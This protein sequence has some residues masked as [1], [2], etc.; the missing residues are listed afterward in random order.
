MKTIYNWIFTAVIALITTT[1]F[2]QG[3]VT[4]TVVDASL[5]EPLPGANVMVRGS[6]SGTSTDFDGNFTLDVSQDSGTI[7][8][9]YIGFI[10]K[11]VSYTLSG[12]TANIGTVSLQPDAEELEGV[13]VVGSGVIDL[14][15]DRQTPIA[16]S[17]VKAEEIA[18]KSGNQEFPEILK[19]TPSIYTSKGGGGFGDSRMQTRGFDQSNT[20]FLINGQPINGME[21]GRMYW[22]NWQG[23][24]DVANA[25]QVQRGLGSSKLAI[26]SVGGTI[27]IVTKTIDSKEGGFLQTMVGNDNYLKT[28][29]YYSTGLSEKGWS[30]STLLGHWQGDGYNHHMEGNGQTYFI[31]AGYVPNDKHSFNFLITGA[32][33]RHN[34]RN[35]YTLATLLEKGAKYNDQW[36]YLNGEIVNTSGNYYHKPIANLNWDWNISDRAELSTV[37]YASWGRGGSIGLR[38][39]G[40]QREDNFDLT[41]QY[42]YNRSI[43]PNADGLI[44]G[45]RRA[46]DRRADILRSSVNEH[47]WYGVVSNFNYEINDVFSFNV[48]FDGRSYHGEHYRRV[49]DFLGL[50]G[51]DDDTNNEQLGSDYVVTESYSVNPWKATFH[52]TPRDQRI[53]Y[54]NPED[55]R[56]FGGFGQFEYATEKLSAF[57]QGAVSTQSNQRFDYFNYVEGNEKSEKVT[58][59]GFNVKAGVNYNINNQHNVF[60]NAGHYSRQP[61]QDNMFLNFRNDVNPLLTNEKITGFEAGYGFRSSVFA[62]NVNVYQTTWDDRVVSGSLSTGEGFYQFQGV[63]QVHQGIEVD[64]TARPAQGLQFKGFTSIGQ[65]E[66]DG[67]ASQTVY[68]DNQNVVAEGDPLYLDGVKVGDGAQ[69]TIGVGGQYEFLR[70][71]SVDANY[72]HYD[73]LYAGFLPTDAEF[74]TPDNRGSV[75][76]P[77]YGLL[78]AGLTFDWKVKDNHNLVLRFNMNNVLDETYIAESLTNRHVEEGVET[79]KGIS[80]E[81]QV[82]FGFGRTWNFSIRYKF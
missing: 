30:F 3:T 5:G 73:N 19:S 31:S 42:N 23:V 28:T 53:A 6:S 44:V 24:M 75:K 35:R 40:S 54:D 61:Y 22:S 80:V 70:G 2:S 51:W 81:N 47:S 69:F 18:L 32:P 55:I 74:S 82:Y 17:T 56:Y 37:L 29:G 59:T 8:V 76:L 63:K 4:G 52:D 60:V 62:A 68:D 12:G 27:N 39:Y 72:L 67:N 43:T 21:D 11:E 34:Q 25:V 49:V 48:G 7:M 38:N 1:A 20:A 57:V 26:S 36:G 41:G 77:S 33:Q 13:V 46:D 10:A 79:Y 66:Y 71:L 64:F 78:D 14:A 65:W 15:R 16:V 58:N 50:D 45:E 9:S